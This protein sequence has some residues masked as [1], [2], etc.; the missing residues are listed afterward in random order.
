MLVREGQAAKPNARQLGLLE[1]IRSNPKGNVMALSALRDLLE[2]TR[3]KRTI[4]DL[5]KAISSISTLPGLTTDEVCTVMQFYL[6][7][8]ALAS[9]LADLALPEPPICTTWDLTNLAA[10]HFAFPFL[11]DFEAAYARFTAHVLSAASVP[12]ES[13]EIPTRLTLRHHD[14]G[15]DWLDRQK[16]DWWTSASEIVVRV[17]GESRDPRSSQSHDP[18][19]LVLPPGKEEGRVWWATQQRAATCL[20][21]AVT[22]HCTERALTV[23]ADEIRRILDNVAHTLDEVGADEWSL[24]RQ[25]LDAYYYVAA[26]K[27]PKTVDCRLRNAM[28]L[29]VEA[30]FQATPALKLALGFSAVEALICKNESGITDELARNAAT[31]LVHN[32]DDRGEAIKRIK[33]LYNVRSKVLHGTTTE[34]QLSATKDVRALAAGTLIGVLEWRQHM[35][36]VPEV[37][38]EKEFFD[39]L[40]T[41]K[42]AGRLMVGLSE[43]QY[44]RF[45]WSLAQ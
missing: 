18:I 3:L 5:V 14:L 32:S 15:I 17:A 35:D 29:L 34:A 36:R 37:P 19:P 45:Q 41:A 26:N 9:P 33:K 30:D 25:C 11:D 13:A 7:K 20:N 6:K 2:S 23:A 38:T 39:Q 10:T 21:V 4:H 28:R 22:G 42:T 43:T 27:G 1:R 12:R 44:K 31:L 8:L 16:N 24:V 40:E